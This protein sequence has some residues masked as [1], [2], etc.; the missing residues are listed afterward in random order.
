MAY[1][2]DADATEVIFLGLPESG[3]DFMA[4]PEGQL[5]NYQVVLETSDGVIWVELWPDVAPNHVRNF[6]DLCARATTGAAVPP[7]HPVLHG[8]GWPREGR[9]AGPA[10]GGRGV[11][12]AAPRGRCP[13]RGAPRQRHQLRLERVLHRPPRVARTWT[14]PTAPTAASSVAWRPSRASWTAC[15]CTTN[16]SRSSRCACGSPL[17]PRDPPWRS[18]TNPLPQG[19]PPRPRGQGVLNAAA[20]ATAGSPAFPATTRSMTGVRV[21]L[22]TTAGDLTVEFLTGRRPEARRELRQARQGR[23]L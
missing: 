15:P 17:N 16:S 6:L 3:I 13:V 4:L 22:E 14:G 9:E 21:R 10:Q 8:P 2:K 5:A 20:P 7:H 1:G 19:D 18:T 11:Q 23:L 12:P